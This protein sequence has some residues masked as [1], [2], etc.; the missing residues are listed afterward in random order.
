MR[1]R[2]PAERA[3]ASELLTM[4]KAR[5]A[6]LARHGK[7]KYAELTATARLYIESA[8]NRIGPVEILKAARS[9]KRWLL[10]RER[11]RTWIPVVEAAAFD[12]LAEVG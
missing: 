2:T 1:F 7:G 5:T 4:A 8:M 9:V 12:M 11:M 6:L 3:A 10:E